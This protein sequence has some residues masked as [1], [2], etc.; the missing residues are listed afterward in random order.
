MATP[1][2]PDN[3]ELQ[4]H[5]EDSKSMDSIYEVRVVE[6]PV[7]ERVSQSHDVSLELNRNKSGAR[8]AYNE[9]GMN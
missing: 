1:I 9:A 4:R 5:R 2:Q 7:Q 6:P 3:Q 8:Q